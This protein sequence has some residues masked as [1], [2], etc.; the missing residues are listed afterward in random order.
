MIYL[1]MVIVYLVVFFIGIYGFFSIPG[2]ILSYLMVFISTTTLAYWLCKV[3]EY[4]FD[5]L[6]GEEEDV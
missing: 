6:Y 2:D 4:V 5:R 3:S 1:R